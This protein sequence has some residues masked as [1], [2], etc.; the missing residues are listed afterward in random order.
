M[1]DIEQKG[2][3]KAKEI[4]RDLRMNLL[5]FKTNTLNTHLNWAV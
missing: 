4:Y 5:D 3:Y 1:E 2:L